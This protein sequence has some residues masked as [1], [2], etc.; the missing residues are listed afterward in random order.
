MDL[1]T[2]TTC[3]VHW[4]DLYAFTWDYKRSVF[5]RS[6]NWCKYQNDL[7]RVH[8]AMLRFFLYMLIFCAQNA[9]FLLSD[10]NSILKFLNPYLLGVSFSLFLQR[11]LISMQSS[12]SGLHQT[13]RI[14]G[15]DFGS[16]KD[17]KKITTTFWGVPKSW[18]KKMCFNWLTFTE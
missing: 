12:L 1:D 8:L 16:V 11:S 3:T 14:G 13:Q 17:C 4:M 15:L 18:H 10:G 2:I 6:S 9:P 5:R 7:L